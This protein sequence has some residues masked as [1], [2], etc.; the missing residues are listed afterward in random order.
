MTIASQSHHH[1]AHTCEL[2]TQNTN[3]DTLKDIIRRLVLQVRTACLSCPEKDIKCH[4][5]GLT[6]LIDEARQAGVDV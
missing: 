1:Q 3:E 2:D 6:D 5:C 4:L